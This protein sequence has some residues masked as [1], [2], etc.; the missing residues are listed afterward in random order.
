M[1]RIRKVPQEAR[2]IGASMNQVKA[3]CLECFVGSVRLDRAWL[4]SLGDPWQVLPQILS[5]TFAQ[6]VCLV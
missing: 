3:P 2:S 1:P 6:H 5:K 4:G